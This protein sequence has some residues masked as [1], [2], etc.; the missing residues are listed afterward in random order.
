MIEI[1]AI[2]RALLRALVE[3]AGQSAGARFGDVAAC[4][5]AADKAFARHGGD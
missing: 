1:D 5:M 3:D 4:N 2:D